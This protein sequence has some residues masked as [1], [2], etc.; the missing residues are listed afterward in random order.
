MY[1]TAANGFAFA[2]D[3]KTGR[4]LWRYQYRV[5]DGV[6]LCCGT[7]NRGLAMPGRR[8]ELDGAIVSTFAQALLFQCAR[9]VGHVFPDC[10]G[11][12]RKGVRIGAAHRAAKPTR[13][14]GDK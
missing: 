5:P 10:T 9:T 12:Q 13:A 1:L 14:I 11:L 2:L 8:Y 6:K 4:E 3:P 7:L